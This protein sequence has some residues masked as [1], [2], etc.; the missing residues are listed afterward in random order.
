MMCCFLI[1]IFI[2]LQN[3]RPDLHFF[4][5]KDFKITYRP[6]SLVP[7]FNI[8]RPNHAEYHRWNPSH[9]PDA[10]L[11]KYH[12]VDI[13]PGHRG[14]TAERHRPC[15]RP[16][17]GQKRMP[18]SKQE[19]RSWRKRETS[20]CKVQKACLPTPK[21]AIDV[22]VQDPFHPSSPAPPGGRPRLGHS[23]SGFGSGSRI[24]RGS[25]SA[26]V[27]PRAGGPDCCGYGCG[28]CGR[29]AQG[30]G[31]RRKQGVVEKDWHEWKLDVGRGCIEDV[32][33]RTSVSSFK[34]SDRVLF[35]LDPIPISAS[36]DP[37]SCSK[38]SLDSSTSAPPSSGAGKLQVSKGIGSK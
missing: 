21:D 10:D 23:G 38:T 8:P 32:G 27:A 1:Q 4:S 11:G 35:P 20:S 28:P 3:I 31:T 15:H 33:D 7:G 6:T 18:S 22:Q 16:F 14:Y 30:E 17:L 25:G 36:L 24:G 29:L 5:N 34:S 13:G 9:Q 12:L 37:W 26:A 2:T 19:L